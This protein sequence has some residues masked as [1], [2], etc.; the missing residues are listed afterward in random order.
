M[1]S[2][3]LLSLLRP[4]VGRLQNA[5]TKKTISPA[6]LLPFPHADPSTRSSRKRKPQGTVVL[7]SSPN[8][9]D[10]KAALST[11]QKRN[12][13]TVKKSEETCNASP[14]NKPAKRQLLLGKRKETE[15]SGSVKKAAKARKSN[16][17]AS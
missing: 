9:A 7:T 12:V 6:E 13:K 3:R 16:N 15:A 17:A 1:K 11:K 14:K 8:V 4:H 10:L 5:I 2:C